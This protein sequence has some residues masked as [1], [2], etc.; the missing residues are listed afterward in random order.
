VAARPDDSESWFLDQWSGSASDAEQQR[1]IRPREARPARRPD[2]WAL[3]DFTGSEDDT[4]PGL[5]TI[6]QLGQRFQLA[7][8]PVSPAPVAPVAR[9]ARRRITEEL[10]PPGV[11]PGRR[12]G[13]RARHAA[14]GPARQAWQARYVRIAALGDTSVGLVAGGIAF[15]LRFGH[16][17]VTVY[18][19]WYLALSL[20]LP[21]FLVLALALNRAYDRRLLFVGTSEYERVVRAGTGLLALTAGVSYMFDVRLARGYVVAALPLAVIACLLLRF[22]LRKQLHRARSR[23]ECLSRVIVVGHELAIVSI[24][25]QLRRE[26]FHGFNVVG[27]CLPT[28]H[29]GHVGLPIYGTLDQVPRAVA[30]ARADTV[31]VLA[32]PELDGEALRR[33]AWKLE[34]DDIDIIVASALVDVAGTRTTIRPVDGLPLLHVEHPR[35]AGGGRVLKTAVDRVGA[36]LLLGLLSP[37]LLACAVAV[38]YRAPGP[39]FFHQVRVGRHGHEFLMHKFRTMHTDAEARLAELRD[40]NDHDGVL[41]KMRDDPRVTPAGRFLRRFSLDELPQ[42]FNVLSGQMS[43]VGPRPPLPA[44]VAVYPADMRRRLAVRPGLTGLWQV[45]GRADLSWEDTVRLDLRYVENWSL[46]LDLVIMLRTV[47]AVFR[48]SGAY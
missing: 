28:G 29:D 26:K 41:F 8:A 22:G 15:A 42:L 18:N 38:R 11:R 31:I 43:L 32:C 2:R 7:S 37:V 45:S 6:E 27:C 12:Y 34:R 33:L 39:V 47:V 1:M 21:V 30:A 14:F 48:G 10:P 17:G 19:R 25:R 13:K 23:G 24:T 44:E 40:R 4:L 20:V 46:S 16:G 5:G 35:L 36:L 3:D 9:P